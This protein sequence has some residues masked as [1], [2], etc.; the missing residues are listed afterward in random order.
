MKMGRQWLLLVMVLLI[1]CPILAAEKKSEKKA[2]KKGPP[3]CPAEQRIEQWTTGQPDQR[4]RCNITRMAEPEKGTPD[5][6]EPLRVARPE[7]VVL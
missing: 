3:K 7:A 4:N 6:S 1:A 5:R 2:A